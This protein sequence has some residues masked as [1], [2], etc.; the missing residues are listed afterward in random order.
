MSLS[1]GKPPPRSN[2]AGWRSVRGVLLLLLIWFLLW[3][4]IGSVI[5]HMRRP[6][7]FIGRS[8]KDDR[9]SA[10]AALPLH[11]GDTCAVV[12]DARHHEQEV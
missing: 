12:F 8:A 7:R 4:V 3:L 9:S 5:L 11:L 1:V 10:F 2:Q 6:V